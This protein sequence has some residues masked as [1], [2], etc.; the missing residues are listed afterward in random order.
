MKEILNAYSNTI[1]ND[2][3][4]FYDRMNEY[5]GADAATA[6]QY[7]LTVIVNLMVIYVVVMQFFKVLK[8][9]ENKNSSDPGERA[10]AMNQIKN[11]IVV[12]ILVVLI[13]AVGFNALLWIGSAGFGG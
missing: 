12:I 8:G 7:V 6:I 11:A 10:A 1:L 5:V 9:I 3:S 13:G 2:S 4:W